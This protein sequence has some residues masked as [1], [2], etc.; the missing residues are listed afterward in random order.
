MKK[1]T[2]HFSSIECLEAR[3]A[4]ATFT[5]THL[6]DDG[7]PGSLRKA[8]NDANNGTGPDTIVFKAGLTGTIHL[9][10]AGAL[11]CDEGITIRGPGS[12]KLT[13]DGGGTDRI[14]V[15]NNV[16]KDELVTVSGLTL[17]HGGGGYG[18]AI[19]SAEPISLSD[20]QFVDNTKGAVVG[21]PGG[22]LSVVTN[23]NIT[24]S[25]C[26]FSG[27]GSGTVISAGAAKLETTN[28]KV[29]ITG[30]TF[31]GNYAANY[32]MALEVILHGVK[33]SLTL[34]H[35]IVDQNNGGNAQAG[36]VH[37]TAPDG[38]LVTASYS[39][40]SH[41]YGGIGTIARGGGLSQ[42]GGQLV[43]QNSAFTD[44]QAGVGGA[45][46]TSGLTKATITGSQFLYN[47][48]R[49]ANFTSTGGGAINLENTALWTIS[50]SKF[51]G[52]S[53]NSDAGAIF[54][55]A[56][57]GTI[58]STTI[59]RGNH[60]QWNGGALNLID[61]ADVTINGGTFS[62]NT[63]SDGGALRVDA[64][65]L[66]LQSVRFSTNTA[67]NSGGAI[68]DDGGVISVNSCT[69][70]HNYG[71]YGGAVFTYG[72]FT[73]LN[74]IYRD[75]LSNLFGGAVGTS[76]A[77][78]HLP[79]VIKGGSVTDNRVLTGS[80]GGFYLVSFDSVTVENVLF[81]DNHAA[82]DG[83]GL[84]LDATLGKI[85]GGRFQDNSATH[86]GGVEIYAG[87]AIL[88]GVT[89]TGNFA[90]VS[91]GGLQLEP[92]QPHAVTLVRST[93]TGNDAPTGP[94]RAG[95]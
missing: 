53:S 87:T 10:V 38:G 84:Y 50:G 15:F 61:T 11:G 90:S 81:R 25:K 92:L 67:A 83:G 7:S 41:N 30:T 19:Y 72:N 95:I 77:G 13:I 3:I 23:G 14:F 86:G 35:T 4:P 45:I 27:N 49:S 64:S 55:N 29:S 88:T 91:G 33:A 79:V 46:A 47:Q 2:R 40:F 16:P 34:D 43:V 68:R 94:D 80:G 51:T 6:L 82:L 5:V 39:T 62:A 24:I 78:V 12:G 9:G 54:A 1:P 73:S 60:A 37:V 42:T 28:G 22:A 18:G 89:M 85:T 93:I 32:G 75:N 59:F 76:S 71:D 20:V 52:N 58:N 48:S 56:G 65:K 31:F 44:N 63:A 69:F 17:T 26:V 21:A 70:D 57:K 8:V 66:T 74:T 36:A